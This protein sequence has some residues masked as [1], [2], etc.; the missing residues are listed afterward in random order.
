VATV[1]I[2]E[3]ISAFD[4]AAAEIASQSLSEAVAAYGEA[5]WVLAG[6]TTPVGAYKLLVKDYADKL[7]WAHIKL[8]MGDERCVPAG[9]A[10]SNW[11]Q[12]SKAMIDHLPIPEANKIRPPLG[13]I[14]EKAAKLYEAS[15]TGLAQKE[16]GIPR[17]SHVWF[18][19]GDDGHT[20]SLFPGH[21][22]LLVHDT[23]VVPVHDSPKPPPD[24]ISL[25]LQALRGA[26][27]CL[28]MVTGAEKA[29]IVARALQGDNSLPIAQVVATIEAAG[30]QV[31]WL[32]DKAAASLLSPAP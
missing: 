14:A 17:L 18:G 30:G 5:V 3:D 4:D 11:L 32:L 6:G 26:E 16:P 23:L 21:P 7:D 9:H 25:S 19:I 24:R 20:F 15:L 31:T 29:A 8:V 22:A 2:K 13:L 27:S 12:A 1:I 10:D 28:I